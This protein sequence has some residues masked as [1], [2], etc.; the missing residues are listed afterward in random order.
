MSE[1]DE[2]N[3][4][5]IYGI[6]DAKLSYALDKSYPKTGRFSDDFLGCCRAHN[7]VPHPAFVQRRDPEEIV[8]QGVLMDRVSM[9]ICTQLLPNAKGVQYLRFVSSKLDYEMVSLLIVAL[10]EEKSVVKTVS[11]FERGNW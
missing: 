8:C 10:S 6:N 2:P 4:F 7:I 5:W 1:P 9:K 3:Q 11:G